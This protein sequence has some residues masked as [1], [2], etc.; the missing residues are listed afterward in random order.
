MKARSY[1]VWKPL[2][3]L[4]IC[5]NRTV[6]EDNKTQ[7]NDITPADSND[8]VVFESEDEEV[9]EHTQGCS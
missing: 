4:I 7:S 2:F 8:E 1:Q 6:E 5:K 9:E 3:L